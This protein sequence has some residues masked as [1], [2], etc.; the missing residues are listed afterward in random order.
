MRRDPDCTRSIM[1]L[2]WNVIIVVTIGVMLSS[3]AFVT[4]GLFFSSL[5]LDKQQGDFVGGSVETISR[6]RLQGVLDSFEQRALR[7]DQSS[8]EVPKIKNL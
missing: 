1:R 7:Y 6:E 3:I 2:Y 8:R 4:W 5:V